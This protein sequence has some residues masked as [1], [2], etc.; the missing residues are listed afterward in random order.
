LHAGEPAGSA[1]LLGL[2]IAVATSSMKSTI[3]DS[4]VAG[5]RSGLCDA[6][7]LTRRSK[8]LPTCS[9]DRRKPSQ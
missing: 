8:R 2:L 1:A 7:T 6:A 3:R 5:N 4:V 9:I